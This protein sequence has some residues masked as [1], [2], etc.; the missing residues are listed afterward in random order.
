MIIMN[1]YFNYESDLVNKFIEIKFKSST[2]SITKTEIPIRWGNIDIIN[3]RNNYIPFSKEQCKVLSRQSNA[4][5][6]LKVKKDRGISR[7]T[8]LNENGLS[9]STILNALSQL[10]K[11]KLIIKRNNLYYRNIDFTFPKVIITGYEAKLTDYN[12]AFFQA[13]LNKEYVDYSYIVF[14]LD[15]AN[16]IKEKYY[17]TLIENGIGLIGVSNSSQKRLIR[18][19]RNS[20]V[21]QYIRLANLVQTNMKE[22]SI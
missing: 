14:P 17:N 18:A 8:L 16:K 11:E 22:A 4:R 1:S 13:V 7:E 15:M 21:K 3:I 20:K 2:R 12:K 19:T 10:Q 6:F 9:K 5:L